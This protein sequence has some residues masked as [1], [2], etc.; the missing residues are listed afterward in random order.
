MASALTWRNL[1]LPLALTLRLRSAIYVEGMSLEKWCKGKDNYEHHSQEEVRAKKTAAETFLLPSKY[2]QEE[3]M[4][5]EELMSSPPKEKGW[6]YSYLYKYQGFWYGAKHLQGAITCRKKFHAQ[7]SDVL[8][9]TTPKSGTTW[10]KAI[11]FTLVN[12]SRYPVKKNHPL[13]NKNPHD[14]VPF[15]EANLYD[16][17]IPDQSSLRLFTAHLPYHSLPKTVQDSACK[18][19]YLC[20][21]PK[22]TFVSLWHFAN[23]VKL[24]ETCTN[25]L[26]E[27]FDLFCRGVTVSQ[28]SYRSLKNRPVRDKS[29]E[30]VTLINN[31]AP[32]TPPSPSRA[33]ASPSRPSPFLLLLLLLLLAQLSS[34]VV[35]IL[36]ISSVA[37]VGPSPPHF[38]YL[39]ENVHDTMD[40][41]NEDPLLQPDCVII[42]DSMN[43]LEDDTV[44]EDGEK[45][46]EENPSN[47]DGNGFEGI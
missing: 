27:A 23:N 37:R 40:G 38:V 24:E 2:F 11:V 3:E 32:S 47:I 17:Q 6:M 1:L 36:L 18:I 28:A 12:R 9:I 26:E 42:A 16:N 19:I 46:P 10:L 21:N 35:Q 22:D 20:R 7:D 15:L 45:V 14:L 4:E 39:A 43:S 13:L 33:A 5:S 25:S 30:I 8:L 44:G 41:T 29:F 31:S 34:T